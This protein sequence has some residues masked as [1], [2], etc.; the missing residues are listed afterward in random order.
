MSAKKH[1][2]PITLNVIISDIARA[3]KLRVYQKVKQRSVIQ[4]TVEKT[5]FRWNF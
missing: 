2:E 3:I 1:K 5:N 4:T